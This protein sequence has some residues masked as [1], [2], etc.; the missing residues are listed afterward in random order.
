MVYV[1]SLGYSILIVQFKKKKKFEIIQSAL[2]ET[3]YMY[4]IRIYFVCPGSG[5]QIHRYW[6]ILGV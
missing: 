6:G 1:D 2:S 5:Y 3:H 4:L